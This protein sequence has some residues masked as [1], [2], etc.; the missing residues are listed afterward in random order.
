MCLQNILLLRKEHSKDIFRILRTLYSIW[1][2]NEQDIALE[3]KKVSGYF[4][5]GNMPANDGYSQLAN[6]HLIVQMYL[7]GQLFSFH[8]I[9]IWHCLFCFISILMKLCQLKKEKLAPNY[10]ISP[11]YKMYNTFVWCI[12]SYGW[13][14]IKIMIFTQYNT[15]LDKRT[16]L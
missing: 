16:I 13:R 4:Y 11:I 15:N 9:W 3:R 14:N 12:I 2:S 6:F 7:L 5:F 1:S 8:F 10:K